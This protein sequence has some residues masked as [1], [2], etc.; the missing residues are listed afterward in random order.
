MNETALTRRPARTLVVAAGALLCAAVLA[1]CT[2]SVAP[3]GGAPTTDAVTS[4]PTRTP[5]PPSSSAAS[6]TGAVGGDLSGLITRAEAQA[7]VNQQLTCTGSP[8]E[9]DHDSD[10]R[11]V[12]VTGDC[13]DVKIEA[14]GATVLLQAVGTLTVDADVSMVFVTSADT[15][16]LDGDG[17]TVVWSTGNPTIIDDGIVNVTGPQP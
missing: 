8:F 13:T 14:D 11:V 7:A 12:E 4:T 9:V 2:V 10:A 3:A 15:V 5:S 17:N 6:D 1:G 16:V